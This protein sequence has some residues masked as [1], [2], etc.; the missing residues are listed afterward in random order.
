MSDAARTLPHRES[1]QLVCPGRCVERGWEA[2][3]PSS[4]PGARAPSAGGWPEGDLPG[5]GPDPDPAAGFSAASGDLRERG[6]LP[7]EGKPTAEKLQTLILTE[8]LNG[9]LVF[10]LPFAC[11]TVKSQYAAD[12]FLSPLSGAAFQMTKESG[13]KP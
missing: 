1:L 11:R 8:A 6:T 13:R 10:F 4:P 3:D 9:S 7:K 12:L 2:A 5:L